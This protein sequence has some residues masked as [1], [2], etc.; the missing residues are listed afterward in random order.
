MRRDFY[1]LNELCTVQYSPGIAEKEHLEAERDG[2]WQ[3]GSLK[4]VP[5]PHCHHQSRQQK[6]YPRRY[7]I[8]ISL[9]EHLTNNRLNCGN[10]L[11]T[12]L[13]VFLILFGPNGPDPIP[14]DHLFP[15]FPVL[16]L[17]TGRW[18]F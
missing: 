6:F 17:P 4:E 13:F 14:P 5:R 10:T 18:Q 9:F 8:F 15:L 7:E 16:Q 2:R 1:N 11:K 3:V 12:A